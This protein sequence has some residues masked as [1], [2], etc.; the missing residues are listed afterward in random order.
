MPAYH[1]S[2]RV[3]GVQA[4]QSLRF[5]LSKDPSDL[6]SHA[7][8]ARLFA[9]TGKPIAAS[10]ILTR[11][12]GARHTGLLARIA[13]RT[14]LRLAPRRWCFRGGFDRQVR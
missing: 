9:N 12:C 6:Q 11:I 2:Q 14:R 5:V 8:L 1:P 3:P 4:E 10:Q 13:V 7:D